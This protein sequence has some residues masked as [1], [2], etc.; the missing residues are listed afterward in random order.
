MRATASDLS[1]P[2]RVHPLRHGQRIVPPTLAVP[3]GA[4]ALTFKAIRL[5]GPV[6]RDAIAGSTSLSIATVNRQV[7]ALLSAGLV[8][9]RPDLSAPGAIGR[10]RVPVEANHDA[11]F[12]VG[13]HIGA[14]TTSIVATDLL[15]RAL[16]TVEC[17][18]PSQTTQAAGVRGSGSAQL[19]ALAERLTRYVQ[20]WRR[21]RL[22]WVGVTTG[23]IVDGIAGTVDH[24]RLGWSAA[25]LG[26]VISRALH[27]PVS[28][29]S[30][31][32]AMAAAELLLGRNSSA[33]AD[34]TTL[35][36]YARETVGYALVIRGRVHTPV[37][38]PGTISGLPS[39]SSLIGG[40]GRLEATVSD[41][42]V[43]SAACTHQ[44]LP[45]AGA[46][47]TMAA[48]L[49]AARA[50]NPRACELL[51]ERAR[52]LGE[53]VALLRDLLNPDDVVVGGQAFTS[54]P[55]GMADF[56]A[57]F[58]C[59]SSLPPRRVRMTSFGDQ[60]QQAGAGIVAL[61]SLYADPIGALR[62]SRP[63]AARPDTSRSATA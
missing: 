10:P 5:Q 61:S 26:P 32:D 12:T 25:P 18:T 56:T 38:G 51:A 48:L 47:P 14:R 31:V 22:L 62:R 58:R 53:S 60:V 54:Y 41:E 49:D 15:G 8:R 19:A 28:V 36:V 24:E 23:G 17:P 9:E 37:S 3:D 42:A 11:F 27:L 6:V 50:G 40:S 45:S 57:A 34:A 7:T 63:P 55:E 46:D 33:G 44:I 43:L 1:E 21:R 20:R 59:R 4:A 16:N 2:A 29:A 30:H 39:H 13:V 52:L 35:Y